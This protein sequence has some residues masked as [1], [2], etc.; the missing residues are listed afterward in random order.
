[1]YER[2]RLSDD[3]MGGEPLYY[4]E[5]PQGVLMRIS[6]LVRKCVASWAYG[7]KALKSSMAAPFFLVKIS[8]DGLPFSY[9]VTAKHVAEE[10]EGSDCVIRLNDKQGKSVILEATGV[11]WCG[12]TPLKVRV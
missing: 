7:E 5:Q 9:M 1:M 8:E 4:L 2:I 11:K 3:R 10:L 6:N 12:I